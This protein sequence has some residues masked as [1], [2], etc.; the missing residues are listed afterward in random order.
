MRKQTAVATILRTS[1]LGLIVLAQGCVVADSHI[2]FPIA[3]FPAP[4]LGTNKHITF[5]DADGRLIEEDG[6]LLVLRSHGGPL[7][8]LKTTQTATIVGIRNGRATIR[9]RWV[10]AS[11]WMDIHWYMAPAIGFHVEPFVGIGIVPLIPGY[12]VDL[13]DT[14][15]PKGGP[16]VPHY[17]TPHHHGMVFPYFLP[18][19]VFSGQPRGMGWSGSVTLQ[20]SAKAPKRAQAYWEQVKRRLESRPPQPCSCGCGS[21]RR[22]PHRRSGQDEVLRVLKIIDEEMLSSSEAAPAT[23]QPVAAP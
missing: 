15:Y 4:E 6:L 5:R 18:L 19:P 17:L 8:P 22:G 3:V 11:A 23:S 14:P 7:S 13:R 21:T 9:D 16:L 20:E 10:L 2:T 12:H 1:V